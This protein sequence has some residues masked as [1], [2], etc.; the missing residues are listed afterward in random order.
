M[1]IRD[2]LDE[3]RASCKVEMPTCRTHPDR[4][5]VAFCA[6]CN[7]PL[8]QACVTVVPTEARCAGCRSASDRV[9]VD[10]GVWFATFMKVLLAKP[11][12]IAL[13]VG[14]V[15]FVGLMFF[16][17]QTL[18]PSKPN[19]PEP[20]RGMPI[21]APYLEKTFRL[22]SLGDLW[23]ARGRKKT[24]RGYYRRAEVACRKHVAQE[25]DRYLKLQA[26]LGVA[27]FQFK[28]GKYEEAVKTYQ[29][30]LSESGLGPI[31][32]VAQF[33]LG[34]VYEFKLKKPKHAVAHYQ[35][36]LRFSK[37]VE[38]LSGASSTM[39]NF[40]ADDGAGGKSVLAVASLT[41][42]LSDAG[43]AHQKIKESLAKLT[44]KPVKTDDPFA[45]LAAKAP[46][47][48]KP[49]API[50]DDPLVIIMGR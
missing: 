35:A 14:I 21:E 9:L 43:A 22:G 25:K 13:L 7:A 30:L 39:L 41:D 40:L 34:Q 5:A 18:E 6:S 36:A 17:P 46:V 27:R 31:E 4:I 49:A 29:A 19:V 23:Q 1:T 8:C 12:A 15:L 50:D 3:L 24:A 2:K 20:L 33:R 48:K 45:A 16:L 38:S 47:Q 32:G 28:A 44:G 26:R 10:Q 37:K 42:T 11:W